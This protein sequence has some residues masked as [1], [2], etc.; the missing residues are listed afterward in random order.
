[1]C[2]WDG[3]S[4]PHPQL[5]FS[6]VLTKWRRFFHQMAAEQG[7]AGLA[8]MDTKLEVAALQVRLP[9]RGGCEKVGQGAALPRRNWP[10][11]VRGGFPGPA[12]QPPAAGS[13]GRESEQRWRMC[14]VGGLER[15]WPCQ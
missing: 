2:A 15:G 6:D 4:G 11:S 8:A 3:S 1:M 5:R 12:A 13:V 10:G 9:L 14:W 7:K